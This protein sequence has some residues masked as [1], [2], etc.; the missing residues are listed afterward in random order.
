MKTTATLKIGTTLAAFAALPL[1]QTS[2]AQ[3]AYVKATN[4]EIGDSFGRALALWDDTLVVGAHNEDSAAAGVD[5]DQADDSK[6]NSGAVYV[7]VREAGAWSLQAYLKASNPDAGDQFGTAVAIHGDTLVVGAPNED[8]AS[9]GVDGDQQD[10]GAARSGAAYVFVRSGEVWSQE[11]YLKASNT[12]A[13]DVFGSALGI[14]GDTVVVGAPQESSDATGIDGDQAS[15]DSAFAGAAYVFVRDDGVW[16]QQA[17]LKA[18]NTPH[19][20][21][22]SHLDPEQFGYAVAV[23]G[24]TILV[25]APGEDSN[26]RGVDGD[27]ANDDSQDSGAAYVFTRSGSTWSQEAYLKPSNTDPVLLNSGNPFGDWFGY[28]VALDADTAVVG[29]AY[30]DGSSPGIDGDEEDE[31][32]MDSGAVHVFVRDGGVWSHQAYVKASNPGVPGLGVPLLGDQFGHCVSLSGDLLVVGAFD[33][34]SGSTGIGGDQ[35]DDGEFCAGAA[36]VFEREAGS[37]SQ[38]SYLKASNTQRFD[39][40]GWDVAVSGELVA[41]AARSEDSGATGVGGD[42]GDE[43]ASNAGAVYVFDQTVTSEFV[44]AG[45][46]ANPSVFLPG[47]TSGPIAGAVWDPVVDHTS[48]HPAAIA[49]FMLISTTTLELD[50]GFSGTLL[51]GPSFV[52][53]VPVNPTPSEP[54]ALPIPSIITVGVS[55]C[56]QVGSSSDGFSFQLTNALD[57]TVGAF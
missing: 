2:L 48:F 31:E 22:F 50:L 26:A 21:D 28:S 5:G 45:T 46:P 57:I 35:E 4:A 13:A 42:Q 36:Y 7:Y 17:Y 40:F 24:E 29:A 20:H 41:V 43:S 44:R 14:W 11:A 30:E 3:Q 55:L 18:S 37:W 10:N 33:E 27:Q 15:N 32:A 6:A 52:S 34:D 47:V 39:S 12:G 49:D 51:C 56:T 53:F 54:F 25:G 8:G 9:T 1:A 38:R 16:S 23:A 19:V